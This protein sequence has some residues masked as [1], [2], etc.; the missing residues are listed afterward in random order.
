MNNTE[1][2]DAEHE[3]VNQGGAGNQVKDDAQVTHKTEGLIPSS[4][5]SSHYAAKYLNFDNIPPVDTEVVSMLDV[6]VQH[7]VPRTSPLLSIP[8]SVIPEHN[9]INSPETVTTTST[10]TI[11]SLLSSLFPHLH[12][13]TP[14]LTPTTTEATTSTTIV[15]DSEILSA[16]HQR[17]TDL[18]KRMSKSSKLLITLQHSFQPSNLKSQMLSKSTLEQV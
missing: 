13:T 12:Q 6:N 7:E 1:I 3:N 18:E 15:L 17:I 9:V 11:S 16:L 10:T 14:I 4:S 5:I 8:V 2:V